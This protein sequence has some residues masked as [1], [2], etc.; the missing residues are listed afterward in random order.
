MPIL[1]YQPG[2]IAPVSST[3]A[4]VGHY[5]ESTDV[6][7]WFD[8]GER[9]PPVTVAAHYGPLWYVRVDVAHEDARA[10]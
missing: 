5:G 1:R 4:I 9:L 10:A 3:Y 7:Q 6:A 8:E 2:S